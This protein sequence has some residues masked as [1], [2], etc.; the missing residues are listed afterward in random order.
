M[1]AENGKEGAENDIKNWQGGSGKL[2]AQLPGMRGSY[3]SGCGQ[4]TDLPYEAAI[5]LRISEQANNESNL[6]F[7]L[8]I[9]F[10]VSSVFTNKKIMF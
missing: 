2:R 7:F 10:E 4:D 5:E 3:Y 6:H 9:Q 8:R 1:S